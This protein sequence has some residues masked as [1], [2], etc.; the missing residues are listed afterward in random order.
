[1]ND[2]NN[3]DDNVLS[4]YRMCHGGNDGADSDSAANTNTDSTANERGECC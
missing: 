2:E 3:L 4:D 1:M